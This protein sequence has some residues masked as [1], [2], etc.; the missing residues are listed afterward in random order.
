ME[1]SGFSAEGLAFM[2]ELGARDKA[3][4]DANRTT[5]DTEVSGSAKAFVVAMGEALAESISPD[6][7]AVPKTNGSI[8]PINNDVRFSKDAPPYKD[9]LLFRFWEGTDKKTSPTL[10]VRVSEASVGFAAGTHIGSVDRWRELIDDDSTG[11]ALASALAEL[12]SGRDLELAGQGLKRVPKPYG[13][14]HPRAD[15]LKHKAFQARW[16]VPTPSIIHR[17]PFVG[18]CVE[19]LEAAIRVHRWMVEQQP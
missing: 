8:S 5:Y 19:E 4:L 7:V 17:A 13:E 6:I 14:D 11:A 3:F 18:W 16:P 2:T 9:H 10:F 15:L 1:F 12:S